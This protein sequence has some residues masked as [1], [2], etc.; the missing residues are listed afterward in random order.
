MEE[1][2][3]PSRAIRNIPTD[4]E[5]AA[6]S[7]VPVHLTGESGVGKQ[8]CA[9]LIHECSD[10][11]HAAFVSADCAGVTGTALSQDGLWAQAEGGPLLM[12]NVDVLSRPM[13]EM[14][15][16]SLD[17]S[18]K[19]WDEMAR[20]SAGVDVRVITASARSLFASMKAGTFREDLYYRLTFPP[21][22]S[23]NKTRCAPSSRSSW[24]KPANVPSH[25]VGRFCNPLR[26]DAKGGPD[27][28]STVG[29]R[30]PSSGR[31]L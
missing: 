22:A 24:S 4:L 3:S 30:G 31:R 25:L 8:M 15:L 27:E 14:L 5:C 18:A 23:R 10:R 13:Q 17:H 26:A 1:L 21:S 2:I 11:G 12:T 9:R 20:P 7:N 16:N 28:E 29:S 19:R 6:R